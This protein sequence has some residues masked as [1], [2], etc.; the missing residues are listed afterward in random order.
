MERPKIIANLILILLLINL[1]NISYGQDRKTIEKVLPLE[2]YCTIQV[3]NALSKEPERDVQLSLVRDSLSYS[4]PI[5]TSY[6]DGTSVLNIHVKKRESFE[7]VILSKPGFITSSYN[8]QPYK[9]G[10]DTLKLYIQ[11]NPYLIPQVTVVGHKTKYS[12]VDNP[13]YE[14]AMRIARDEKERRQKS[15]RNYSF[16]QIDNITLSAANIDAV[17]NFLEYVIPFYPSYLIP[18]KIEDEMILPLSHRETVR[19]VGYNAKKKVFNQDIQFKK[20]IGLDQ[21]IDDGTL[22]MALYELFPPIDLFKR[23]VH[24]LDTDIPSPLSDLGRFHYKYYLTDT[25]IHQRKV[26]QVLEVVPHYPNEPSFRGQFIVTMD[27]IPRLLRCELT[28]PHFSNINFI[29]KMRLI[30]NFDAS[31]SERSNLKNEE[32]LANV[33]LY[34]KVLSA[35]IDHTRSYDEYNYTSPDSGLIYSKIRLRDSSSEKDLKA[36]KDQS[37]GKDLLV[38]DHGLKQ[39][40]VRL[41]EHPTHKF[42]MEVADALSV[43]YIRTRWNSNLIYGGSLVE[44]GPLN[45]LVGYDWFNGAR[46]QLGGRTTAL[47]NKR[48]FLS[49]YIAYATGSDKITFRTKGMHSF[50]PKRYYAE[51]FPRHDISLAYGYELYSPGNRILNNDGNNII[52]NVGVPHLT[53][54]SY[55]KLLEARYHYDI[56]SAWTIQLYYNHATDYPVGELEYVRVLPDNSIIRYEYLRDAMIGTEIRWSPEEDI[57]PGS[58]QRENWYKRLRQTHPI[59]TFKLEYASPNLGGQYKRIRSEIS[60]EQ[61][62]WLGAFGRLDYNINGGKIWSSVPFP[63]L[64]DPPLN[65][66]FF[67]RRFSFK[68][69]RRR[70]YVADEWISAF[71]EYHM[72]GVIANRLPLVKKLN[73]RG[74]LTVNLLWGNTTNKNSQDSGKELFV[75]PNISTEMSYKHPY[76]EMGFGLENILKVVRIDVY[77]RL[78]PMGPHSTGP[79]NVKMGLN[80]N[81]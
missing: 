65:R 56:D 12:S 75:L 27:S 69:L 79:W 67:V 45:K 39:F 22:S 71:C 42:I 2:A 30:Q 64:Y 47:L 37:T 11:P 44:I 10:G 38:S 80:L 49:G 70:E 5:T 25:I 7:I 61:K 76:M 60:V 77:R 68:G 3:I 13:A 48:N 15:T 52:F 18:S 73:L 57:F 50:R 4:H 1:S 9:L 34:H 17:Q 20:T 19:R 6:K 63:F 29:E 16:R 31:I 78:T 54:F 58:M 53:Y 51:E 32:L 14:L 59:F 43:N 40:M 74:V 72:R 81:F 26:A 24:M 33:R 66:N 41:R 62:L 23:H 28:F 21:N 8:F 46:V 55:R 36:Y 35:N